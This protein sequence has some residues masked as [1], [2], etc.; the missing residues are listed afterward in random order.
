VTQD[1]KQLIGDLELVI[2]FSKGEGYHAEKDILSQLAEKEID[3]G[4]ITELYSEREPCDVCESL[5][6][7]ESLVPD[8]L[9]RAV[10]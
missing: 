10:E 1:A 6:N 2:G 3:P 9:F 4:R 5:L 8:H 7:S